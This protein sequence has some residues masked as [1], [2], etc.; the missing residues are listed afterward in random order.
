M[1][2]ALVSPYSWS[3][4]GGVNE[5]VRNLAAQLEDRGHEAWIIAP[6]RSARH[7]NQTPLPDRFLS[8]GG[9]VPVNSNGS[10]AYVNAWPLMLQRMERLLDEHEFDLMHAHEPCTP[11]VSASAVVMST[12]PVVGTF[13]R[14]GGSTWGYRMFLPLARKVVDRLAVRI[15]VSPLARDYAAEFFPGHFRIIPNGVDMAD[16]AADGHAARVP[17]RIIFIGRPERRKGLE[18]LLQAWM[19]VK[20][21]IPSASLVVLGATE[22]EVE[23]AAH[24]SDR[25]LPWPL[26]DVV[27]LG[28][29]DLRGKM[30][31][32]SEAQA[33][34]VPSLR[35]ES[36]G[37][38]LVEGMAAG[39]PVVASDIPAYRAV[40]DDGELG[41]LV[42]PGD[43]EALAAG[44]V[45]VLRNPDL[46][47]DLTAR[48]LVGVEAYAWPRVACDIMTAYDEALE[49]SAEASSEE[50]TVRSSG[51]ATV[52]GRVAR[53]EGAVPLSPAPA[54][55]GQ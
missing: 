31:A 47:R 42:P 29:V 26:P 55:E 2:I 32:M 30:K 1:R 5:H 16:F 34:A 41:R 39:V 51:A 53:D 40:L 38:V 25:R 9:A 19:L 15:A 43:P 54:T 21:R 10:R 8:A 7:R 18:V 48:A 12:V 24:K 23:D 36:F 27:A 22:T 17:G 20:E 35:G 14:S 4:P 28:R 37:I 44:L 6:S 33:L 49:A 3:V 13:H 45:A 50:S 11:S 52:S 46:R